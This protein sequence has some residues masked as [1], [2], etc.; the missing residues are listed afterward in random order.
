MTE[1]D[2]LRAEDLHP[3]QVLALG[4]HKVTEDE[5]VEFAAAWDPQDFHV[6]RE[7]AEKRAYGGLIASGIHTMAIYQR[8]AVNGVLRRLPVIAGKRLADTVFLRPVRPG[9]TLT[10]KMIVDAVDFDDRGR[11]LITSTGELDNAEGKAVFRTVVEAYVQA[12][13]AE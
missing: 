5:I 12:S 13:P 4:S 9:D 11:A 8:L 2:R 7:L 6:D 1:G 3:G 10:G